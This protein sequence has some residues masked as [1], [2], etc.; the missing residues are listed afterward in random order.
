MRILRHWR[1]IKTVSGFVLTV[2]ALLSGSACE[3]DTEIPVLATA[4][5]T[6]WHIPPIQ[7]H[8][9]G[10]R[11]VTIAANDDLVVLDNG[12]RILVYN[13]T[14]KVERSW[15]MPEFDVGRPEGTVVL[16]DGRIVVCDTH[17]H[18]IVVFE[19]R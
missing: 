1:L 2:S 17:Y 18:R 10:P 4:S 13:S 3:D 5:V 6:T 16:K 9:P 15:M 7:S 8:L 19:V 14:G 11:S 12:G